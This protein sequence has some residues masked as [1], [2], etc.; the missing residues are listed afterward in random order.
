MRNITP[1]E[2]HAGTY[3][4][5]FSANRFAHESEL[6]AV[7]HLLPRGGSVVEVGVGTGR[8][9][10]ELG[11]ALG[12][13]PSISMRRIARERGVS[14]IGGKAEA[15]PF[16]DGRFDFVLMVTTLCFFDD[17]ERSLREAH[18]ILKPAG[19]L[20][21]GFIDRDSPLGKT[22]E[23]RKTGSLFYRQATFHSASEVAGF[24]ED[25][26]FR[27]MVFAQTIFRDPGG[28]DE[29]DPVREGYGEGCF[30]VVRADK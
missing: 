6:R 26:G 9:A 28:M 13:E 11:I 27:T 12:V 29:A 16:R 20:V 21:I 8:F 25:A 3:D 19:S 15:L 7:R 5:W 18:R 2:D 24:L 23:E 4:D 22:Y 10:G 14:V 1:F 30:V 17:V